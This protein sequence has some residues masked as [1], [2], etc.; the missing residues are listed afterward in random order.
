MYKNNFFFYKRAL[1]INII[2]IQSN[3]ILTQNTYKILNIDEL[4]IN[5]A[6]KSLILLTLNY[7]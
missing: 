1:L 6:L 4:I 7:T 2:L 3:I 5:S